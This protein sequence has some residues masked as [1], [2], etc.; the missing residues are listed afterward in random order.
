MTVM[1]IIS[2]LHMRELRP[3]ELKIQGNNILSD[4]V[5]GTGR[6]R[7]EVENWQ[8]ACHSRLTESF[9]FFFFGSHGVTF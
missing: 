9:F 1:V 8:P 2:I 5:V 3:R 7:T 6:F 4:T